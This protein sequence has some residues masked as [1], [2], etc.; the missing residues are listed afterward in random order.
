VKETIDP[1]SLADVPAI[2][3]QDLQNFEELS[4]QVSKLGAI[5][6]GEHCTECAYPNC[7]SSCAFYT[8]RWDMNCRR[9][10]SGI[11]SVRIK[12][13][14]LM[15]IQFRQWGKLEGQGPVRMYSPNIAKRRD[16]IDAIVG[17]LILKVSPTIR[18]KK[19]LAWRWDNFKSK[20]SQNY[21]PSSDSTFVVEAWTDNKSEIPCTL[22]IIPCSGEKSALFQTGFKFVHG[23]NRILVPVS[24]ISIMVNLTEPYLIQFEPIGT[25]PHPIYFGLLT[26]TTL[27]Q[28]LKKDKFEIKKRDSALPKAKCIVWDLDNTLWSGTL[29]E[30][31]IEGLTLCSEA[32][33]AIKLLD[34]RGILHSIAS[35]NDT[36]PAL[37]AL[38]HFGIRD[39]FIFPQISWKPKSHSI[40]NIA[41]DIDIGLNTLI[42]IDDQPFE[43]GEVSEHLPM[44]ECLPEKII[45]TLTSH[46]RLQV[47]VTAEAS[48]RRF[49]YKDQESRVE[50]FKDL[51]SDNDTF[52]YSC[53]IELHVFP[54]EAEF[55]DRAYELSQ[56]TNQL[57]FSGIRYTKR[58]LHKLLNTQG[59]LRADLLS[60]SDRFGDYGIIGFC[61]FDIGTGRVES[62]MMSCR[63][64]RKRVEDAYFAYLAAQIK[65]AGH[66][67]IS[68][69][70]RPTERNTAAKT[71][72]TTLG[73]EFHKDTDSNAGIY[74][75]NS[76][77]PFTGEDIVNLK[78]SSLRNDPNNPPVSTEK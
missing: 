64:Q 4:S 57:N 5:V 20:P 14:N 65:D 27:D 54:L 30:D 55:L 40:R 10:Q 42:F 47:T 12:D 59:N 17:S 39:Y 3:E 67:C 78:A 23:Y 68:V 75:R 2:P 35:K 26:F 45:S 77:L 66:N 53:N 7:Y 73:F 15:K 24:E 18:I 62:F 33:E 46:P 58:D 13:L 32:V 22:T 49:M 76:K 31:G 37:A 74:I 61:I 11:E 71:M 51:G 1:Y 43:R 38:E 25:P 70:F 72:L 21:L 19:S 8:P 60:C 56:R 29:A 69:R 34:K 44:I 41:K 48:R 28:S 16:N 63:V 52:L 6:W 9:F 36:S 50:A